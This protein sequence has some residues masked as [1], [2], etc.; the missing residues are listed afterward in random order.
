MYRD[1]IMRVNKCRTNLNVSSIIRSCVNYIE[2]HVE[3]KVDISDLSK[4]FG[5]TDYYLSRKF[6][7]Q[8]GHSVN[9]YIKMIKIERAKILLTSTDNTILQISEKLGFCSRSYFGDIF[10]SIVGMSAVTYR[11]Q[12]QTK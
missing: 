10:K 2:L 7:E 9:D 6:K 5:Y 4:R 12:Y 11:E 1:F 8:V 3:G